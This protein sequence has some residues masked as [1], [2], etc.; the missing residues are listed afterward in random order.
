MPEAISENYWEKINNKANLSDYDGR[1]KYIGTFQSF[2]S[3]E[4]LTDVHKG[5]LY[6]I[7]NDL[8]YYFWDGQNWQSIASKEYYDFIIQSIWTD[9]QY[10]EMMS[11]M[12]TYLTDYV[13]TTEITRTGTLTISVSQ[14]G[15]VIG[16]Y[17]LADESNN[18]IPSAINANISLTSLYNYTTNV[19]AIQ[20]CPVTKSITG[21][22]TS[23]SIE[24]PVG[25][26]A[27][28]PKSFTISRYK[29]E[30][31]APYDIITV[32]YNDSN[33]I[34]IDYRRIRLYTLTIQ[35]NH[36]LGSDWDTE[37]SI[38]TS[39]G[40]ISLYKDSIGGD[41]VSTRYFTNETE[42]IS[43]QVEPDTTYYYCISRYNVPRPINTPLTYTYSYR[44]GTQLPSYGYSTTG[45]IT[46][47]EG[48]DPL[49]IQDL[50]YGEDNQED[51]FSITVKQIPLNN[52]IQNISDNITVNLNIIYLFADGNY[53]G[54]IPTGYT[55]LLRF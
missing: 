32:D 4:D 55:A 35:I 5:D 10:S 29:Y 46:D 12:D 43:Y 21:T 40:E 16:L 34:N 44:I 38:P 24:L 54:S 9:S 39:E 48:S 18:L 7:L 50:E 41:V 2:A 30:S 22:N 27:I 45:G 8:C 23:Q 26:Y 47:P 19:D 28:V 52:P 25:L 3:L 13:N 53:S 36:I 33:N 17:R 20:Q 31:A 14:G 42:S 11:N 6:R 1:L 51:V 15:G 37:L 49:V